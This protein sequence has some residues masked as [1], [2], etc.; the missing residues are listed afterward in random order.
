MKFDVIVIGGGLSAIMCGIALAT[1]GKRVALMVKGQSKLNFNSGSIDLLGY[2]E[3]GNEVENP[4]DFIET[5]SPSHPY[6][7]MGLANVVHNAAMAP[8]I[9]EA[10]GL[11]FYGRSSERNHYRMTP[12]GLLRPSWLT[13]DD[14]VAI[15]SRKAL[16]WN[17]VAVVSI[18]S[19]LDF[20][21]DFVASSFT[22]LGAQAELCEIKL[23]TVDKLTSNPTVMRSTAVAKLMQN[24]GVLN[25]FA[26][27]IRS[28]VDDADLVVLPA[29]FGLDGDDTIQKITKQIKTPVRFVSTLPPCIAGSRLLSKLRKRFVQNGGTFLLGSMVKN[30]KMAGDRLLSVQ[31]KNFPDQDIVADHFVLATGSFMSG[32]LSSSSA[33]IKEPIFGLDVD[34]SDNIG[35][36]SKESLFDAQPYM[37]FGVKT[38]NEFHALKDG[39][40]IENL[41]AIG[42]ILSG[43]NSLK[44]ADDTGVAVMTALQVARQI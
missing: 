41:F 26:R 33:G 31:A 18:H 35:E 43:H 30:G 15:D 34:Y 19:F 8:V 28:K 27:K 2:D 4:L 5:L 40:P 14:Y 9:L 16:S 39:R 10:A 32:G 13:L 1:N 37:E 21:A 36:W 11:S 24:D 7:K 20:P 23:G 22:S 42:S 38:D 6:S 3:Q 44:L 29:V 17:K 25:D 12:M